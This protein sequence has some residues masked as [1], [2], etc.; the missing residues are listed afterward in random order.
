[1]MKIL[2]QK[3]TF[4]LV[5]R[6]ERQQKKQMRKKSFSECILILRILQRMKEVF[7]DLNSA[8]FNELL[9][10]QLKLRNGRIV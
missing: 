8:A 2:V 5:Q 4:T 3:P 1:M 7:A 10:A 6:W 9:N